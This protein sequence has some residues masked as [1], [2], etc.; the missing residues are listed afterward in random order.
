MVIFQKLF[1]IS[2][3]CLFPQGLIQHNILVMMS[4]YCFFYTLLQSSP[5]TLPDGGTLFSCPLFVLDLSHPAHKGGV[6]RCQHGAPY[7]HSAGMI[8]FFLESRPL[9]AG[10]D[11]AS[12]SLECRMPSRPFRAAPCTGRPQ[13][14]TRRD[15][16]PLGERN[17]SG[18]TAHARA[19]ASV[20]Q[21][22]LWCANNST[23]TDLI[24]G[25]SETLQRR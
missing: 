14:R 11:C 16:S 22:S 5:L 9:S 6:L 2:F 17:T 3:L 15:L 7:L 18:T 8:R 10:H 4:F 23:V 12:V 20:Y 25:T 19:F 13:M 21:I 24:T 1:Y